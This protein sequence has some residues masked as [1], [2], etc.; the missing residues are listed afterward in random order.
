MQFRT[1]ITLKTAPNSISYQDKIMLLGSCFSSNIGS[2]FK[3][4][5]FQVNINPFGV[6]YNPASICKSINTLIKNEKKE[7]KSLFFHQGL[8]HSFSHHSSFSDI[9]KTNTL[10]AINTSIEQAHIDLK[11][12]SF[13]IITLGTAWIY[14]S[15]DTQTVVANC[16][17]LADKNFIRRKLTVEEITHN[18]SDTFEKLKKINP[19]IK[20]IFTVSPI[21][22]WKD[23]AHENQISKSTLFLAIDK[24]RKN[25][26]DID[27]FP[28]YEIMIDDLRDYSFYKE[29]LNHPNQTAIQYI[30]KK[31]SETYFSKETIEIVKSIEKIQKAE[32]HKAFNPTSKEHLAFIRKTEQ[33][34]EEL[35]KE[36]PFLKI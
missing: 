2:V 30:W 20:I 9:S 23:G 34:K 5:K 12:A 18:F 21:R 14:E 6:I 32:M 4:K 33:Q 24:L 13:L 31:L 8:W 22:H 26:L 25:N 11:N 35:L 19:N 10:H 28:A 17:K 7:E 1:E 3:D 29:D 27:Y 15:V 36:Y 16:H